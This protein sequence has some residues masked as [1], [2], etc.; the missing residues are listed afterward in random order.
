MEQRQFVRAL[1]GMAA[2]LLLAPVLMF[3]A[4]GTTRWPMAWLYVALM[5]AAA[6]GSRLLVWRRSP[7]T[8]RER[9][10][11]GGGENVE[12]WDRWMMP[13]VGL[14]G[15][16]VAVLVAGFD[17][18]WGWSPPVALGWQWVA[19]ALVAAAIGIS[20]WAMAVNPFFSSVARVQGERGQVAVSDGPYAWV[21]HPSYAGAV[22]TSLALPV[23]LGTLWAWVPQLLVAGVLVARTALEDRMLQDK[24]AGYQEYA[25]RVRWR[26]MPGV[27]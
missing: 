27:W 21:R 5:L 9:A 6:V 15:P 3:L 20:V 16:V 14:I 24:L 22:L 18:R 25:Q 10:K 13:V 19:A 17:Q 8:L 12:P 26:L 11:M 23:M 1:I 2:Y 7:D 4:A